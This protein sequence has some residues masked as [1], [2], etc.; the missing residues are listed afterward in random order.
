MRNYLIFTLLFII[1]LVF[2]LG[3][4]FLTDKSAVFL[5]GYALIIIVLWA[6]THKL[7][8]NKPRM[9]FMFIFSLIMSLVVTDVF[10]QGYRL[11]T[12]ETNGVSTVNYLLTMLGVVFGIFIGLAIFVFFVKKI[13]EKYF[14]GEKL[15]PDG[16]VKRTI[17]E[18][19]KLKRLMIFTALAVYAIMLGTYLAVYFGLYGHF[20]A[21]TIASILFF[22]YLFSKISLS[23][24]Y[25]NYVPRNKVDYEVAVLV[26][27]FNESLENIQRQYESFK[28]QSYKNLKIYYHDDGSSTD[29]V[30][31][32]LKA[33]ALMDANVYV[34]KAPNQGKRK[35]QI[36]LLKVANQQFIYTTDSDTELKHDCIE[37]LVNCFE[38]KDVYAVT[39][40]VQASNAYDNSFTK[41]LQV[42]YFA[43][44]ESER[45]AQ[46]NFGNVIVC[47]G[48]NSMYRREVFTDNVEEYTNQLFLGKVQH[49]GDDRCLT[50]F[51]M[52]YGTAKYQ[53]NAI[54]YTEIPSD[55]GKF[56]K[57]QIRWNRSFIRETYLG[58][59]NC[60]EYRLPI[61]TFLWMLMEAIMVVVFLFV[62]GYFMTK[63]LFGNVL[64]VD[65]L[66]F[67]LFVISNS[68]I[69]NIFYIPYDINLYLK[70]PI[71]GVIHAFW[72]TPLKIYSFI[73]LTVTKWG[74]R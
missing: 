3:F 60:I 50:N 15:N 32:W 35:C 22:F 55:I 34:E 7:A 1:N 33:V 71:Y 21:F 73:T 54:T 38:Q 70:M 49:V 11:V 23:Y 20:P 17:H 9:N 30:Y 67:F 24:T 12:G 25:R 42:R 53:S 2:H 58:I 69:R 39:G 41:L 29:E 37:E 61:A 52:R 26:P 8:H 5:L 18:N 36:D 14:V 10:S 68:Y 63:M 56:T 44:F 64:I 43:A 59:K 65:M 57:Q 47:S 31:E 66:F 72:V 13:S 27:F 46:S 19:L 4:L 45:A 62:T 6:I 40:L 28:N 74:T 16:S 48:P 51:A